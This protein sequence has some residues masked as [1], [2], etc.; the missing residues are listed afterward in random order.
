MVRFQKNRADQWPVIICKNCKEGTLKNKI[1]C[2]E[3]GMAGTTSFIN[4]IIG[5]KTYCGKKITSYANKE[6]L[7]YENIYKQTFNNN[8]KQFMPK[9][10]GVYLGQYMVI[11]NL[12][13]ITGI[14]TKTMDFKIGFKSAFKHNSNRIK[15]I[16]HSIINKVVSLSSEKGYRLEGV[17]PDNIRQQIIKNKTIYN[18]NVKDNIDKFITTIIKTNENNTINNTI[19]KLLKIKQKNKISSFLSNKQK[20]YSKNYYNIFDTYYKN[21]TAIKHEKEL[22]NI[23]CKFIVPNIKQLLQNKKSIGLIGSSVL[24]S[25]GNKNSVVKLIDF[26][27]ATISTTNINQIKQV[28]NYSLGIINLLICLSYYNYIKYKHK[29]KYICKLFKQCTLQYSN[30]F[31]KIIMKKNIKL[32]KHISIYDLLLILKQKYI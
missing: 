2:V 14:N 10:K 5:N 23:V 6:L 31:N 11:E 28:I 17:T 8:C 26:A 24:F 21:K 12:K 13:D 9:Y 20:L 15:L 29:N 4:I 27:H 25:S 19:N 7:F 3:K 32:N 18:D 30:A 22:T 1:P 16:R